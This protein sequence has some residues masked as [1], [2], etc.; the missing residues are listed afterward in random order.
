MDK[1]K[2]L[3]SFLLLTT[4]FFTVSYL[5]QKNSNSGWFEEYPM[6]FKEAHRFFDIGV[7]DANGDNN[8]DIYTSNHH[9]RQVLLQADGQG[10]YEDIFSELGLD[11]SREFPLAELTFT[12]PELD[13]PGLYLYWFGSQFLIRT[14]KIKDMGL[15]KGT[16]HV[17]DPIKIA[18]ND[19]FIVNKQQK[20]LTV[21]DN[22][23]VSETVLSF[24]TDKD[25]NLRMKP[26]GQG[27]P[28]QFKINGDIKPEQIFV[29]LG[30]ISPKSMEFALAMKD[31]H[32]MV[33]ADYNSD[34]ELDVFI[35]RGALGGMLR[36]YPDDVRKNISDELLVRNEGGQY[37]DITNEAGISKRDCSGRHARW[38]DFN[39]D[40]RLD[41]FNNCF[42]RNNVHGEFPKQLYIQ[43][44]S[45]KFRDMATE[46]GVAIPNQQIGSF[47]WFD[48]DNDGD[49][50]LVTLQNEGFFL[51][52]NDKEFLTQE[53][54]LK[55]PL[56]GISI[57]D[58]TEGK[59][60]YDG[61][62]TV[63]DYD[64]DGDL[65]L[66]ASSKRDNFLFVNHKGNFTSVNLASVGL[67]EKSLN[68]SWV[69]YDNDGLPDLYTVPQGVFRQTAEHQFKATG[70]LSYLDEQYQA[71]VS[72]WFDLDND[73]RQDLLMA[74]NENP[75]FRHWWEF[76]KK[77]ALPTTWSIKAYRNLGA[78]NHWLQI[79]L[80]G[81]QGNLQ[82]IGAR[83]T[84]ITS[85][86]QQIQ[87]VGSNEGS[88]FSQGHYRLYFGLGEHEKADRIKIQWPDGKKQEIVNILGDRLILIE[89][90]SKI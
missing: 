62:L 80:V 65:D 46:I 67:P 61:K 14:H 56:S 54:I 74:L 50:D 79:K 55:R 19:G 37:S 30:K 47:A 12:A 82:A 24:S 31:R 26:G 35:N 17:Y 64:T 87:E 39:Q 58:S 88:F 36:V 15:L 44:A 3:T 20:T 4:L 18:K 63:A 34:G 68:A 49:V 51:Y 5:M 28:L 41:L 42:D 7:V 70:I 57:G 8:L 84:V 45:G 43:D 11:Q 23:A 1:K 9:F 32:A 40:G 81:A 2:L 83:V 60:V 13:K 10:G 75:S 6:P 29:G 77:V 78:L 38:L 89:Q 16:L 48:V 27:L 72:N 90:T 85:N 21:L 86:G 22:R 53:S 33:W 69:D 76:D 71:A 59:W 52:R 66:F 25:A 73:G